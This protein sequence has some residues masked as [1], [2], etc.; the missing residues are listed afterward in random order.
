MPG[1]ACFTAVSITVWPTGASMTC[2]L[3]LCSMYVIFGIC[4]VQ[5]LP[6]TGDQLLHRPRFVNDHLRRKRA[7]SLDQ[8][9]RA[10]IF[11]RTVDCIHGDQPIAFVVERRERTVSHDAAEDDAIVTLEEAGDLQFEIE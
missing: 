3:P 2:S 9:L 6:R 8:H 10:Q 11:A 7:S 4:P 5:P 1:T